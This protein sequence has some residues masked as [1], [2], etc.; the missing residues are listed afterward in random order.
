M[1][2]G[3]V[4]MKTNTVKKIKTVEISPEYTVAA[5]EYI[6][7]LS[8]LRWDFVYQRPQHLMSRFARNAKVLYFE[9]P[10][11]FDGETHLSVTLK[12][13]NL[14]VC[15]PFINYKEEI[16]AI[17]IQRS[18]INNTIRK[19]KIENYLLWF[20]T[21]MAM[22][23]ASHLNSSVT[24]F[25]CMDELT[26]FKFAPP[27]LVDMEKRLLKKADLVFTGGQ[28]LYNAKK[29]HH[30]NVSAFPSSI[31]FKHF[32]KARKIVQEPDDQIRIP[33]PKL[34]FLGVIDERMDTHLLAEMADLRPD[35][36][37]VM[38]G[39][40]VKISPED[41]PCRGNIHYLGGKDYSEL[42]AYLS[43]WDIALM[44][45]AMNESTRFIS[46]TKTP[47]YLAAGKPVISTPIQDVVSPYGDQN[48]VS[49]AKTAAEFIAEAEKIFK[50][51]NRKTWLKQ[52][53]EFLSLNS[54]DD[55]FKSMTDL[56]LETCTENNY[57]SAL[58]PDSFSI[59]SLVPLS[60]AGAN[61]NHLRS[62]E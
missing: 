40:V 9:E 16:N 11:F 34:G 53:D 46:P 18:M 55:T 26:A 32:S 59:N 17:K 10:I 51:E 48:L 58:K 14:S 30:P 4:S 28:S 33:S 12:D 45:F 3:A 22:E 62:I 25:D 47:E 23:F 54:W 56:I 39:P 19:N 1:N 13:S 49:I 52:V 44:P 2:A 29:G 38:I 20:Y 36:Q 15:T 42:P 21:P 8:H 24:V 27:K 57:F 50:Q 37:F 43:G 5:L 31:D 41:L 35:W 6:I 60:R 61:P 7:C